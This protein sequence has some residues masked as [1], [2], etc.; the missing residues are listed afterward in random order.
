MEKLRKIAKNKKIKIYSLNQ[1]DLGFVNK[2]WL[3]DAGHIGMI[4]VFE[5]KL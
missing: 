4:E 5:S 3:K 2:D 1:R